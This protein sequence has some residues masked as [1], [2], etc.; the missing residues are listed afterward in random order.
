MKADLRISI[1]DYRR[2][3]NLKI[4]LQSARFSHRQFFVRMNG[5]P[6]PKDGCPVSL[7]KLLTSIRKALVKTG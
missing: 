7:T 5:T 1:K 2:N 4:L 3:K 6:W